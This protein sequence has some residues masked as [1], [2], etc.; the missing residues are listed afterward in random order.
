MCRVSS[1][2]RSDCG[3]TAEG[4]LRFEAGYVSVV[5]WSGHDGR[6]N[7][8]CWADVDA[9]T[10]TSDAL[11]GHGGG[12]APGH[13]AISSDPRDRVGGGVVGGGG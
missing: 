6:R 5:A 2:V 11:A 7:E 8:G 10:W 12:G 13:G 4:R 1:L 9:W 3:C